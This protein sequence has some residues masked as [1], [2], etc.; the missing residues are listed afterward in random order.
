MATKTETTAPATPEPTPAPEADAN[1]KTRGVPASRDLRLQV[2]ERL[3]AAK[4]AGWTRPGIAVALFERTGDERWGGPDAERKTAGQGPVWRA[5]NFKIHVDE[6]DAVLAFLDDVE[7]GKL[8]PPTRSRVNRVREL[9]ERVQQALL[10]LSGDVK[11]LKLPEL[12][13]AI[14]AARRALGG[15][16]DDDVAADAA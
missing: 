12:R 11:R 1:D 8:E 4:A 16:A 15:D 10:E 5:Q 14:V 13:E 9:E 3:E 7:A 6:V 2:A